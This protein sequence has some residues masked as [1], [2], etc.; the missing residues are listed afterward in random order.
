MAS[1]LSSGTRGLSAG[2]WVRLKR[3]R[4]A[5]SYLGEIQNDVDTNIPTQP[6][7]SYS[8]PTLIKRHTG[9]SRIRRPA[10]NWIEYKASQIADFVLQSQS[11]NNPNAKVLETT[12]LCNCITD[13]IYGGRIQVGT[14]TRVC[15]ETEAFR[16]YTF[17]PPTTGT[18]TISL[19]RVNGSDPD[20][21]ISNPGGHINTAYVVAEDEGDETV[22]YDSTNGSG[23]DDVI[24]E[25]FEGGQTYEVM[26]FQ[27]DGSCFELT[28]TD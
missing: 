22:L 16:L 4:G 28:V 1:N 13:G 11:L 6:Q 19:L 7:N 12:Q 8:V 9:A 18:Y 2:D 15:Q 10:S 25:T 27:Y 21:F 3:L 5:R 20:L 14:D 26:V 23:Y 17:T 24:T